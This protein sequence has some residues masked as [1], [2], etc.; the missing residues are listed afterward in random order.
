MA[1]LFLG[2]GFSKTFGIPTM[3]E[4]T[5]DLLQLKL[6]VNEQNLLKSIQERLSSYEHYDIEAV[7]TVLDYL[8]NPKKMQREVL[9]SAPIQFFIDPKESWSSAKMGALNRCF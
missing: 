7:M 9:N 1:V 2:A 6:D 5:R 4:M 8:S 3:E